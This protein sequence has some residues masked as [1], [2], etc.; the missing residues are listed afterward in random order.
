MTLQIFIHITTTKTVCK[1]PLM[2]N[3]RCSTNET[4]YFLFKKNLYLV[5]QCYMKLAS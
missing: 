3:I 5:Q 4:I 2:Q 1:I